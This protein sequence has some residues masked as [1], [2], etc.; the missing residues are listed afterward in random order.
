M[1]S[2]ATTIAPTATATRVLSSGEDAAG[3]LGGVSTRRQ[4]RSPVCPILVVARQLLLIGH[5][6]NVLQGLGRSGCGCARSKGDPSAITVVGRP[7]GKRFAPETFHY[8]NR[9]ARAG[10]SATKSGPRGVS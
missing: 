2:V 6:T 5:G 9:S 7:G 4:L 1:Y 3:T 8:L 10:S